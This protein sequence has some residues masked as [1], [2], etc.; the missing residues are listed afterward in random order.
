MK[1]KKQKIGPFLLVLQGPTS[2]PQISGF[3]PEMVTC[4]MQCPGKGER[5]AE[6]LNLHH[7]LMTDDDKKPL[8]YAGDGNGNNN[9]IEEG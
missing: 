4:Q 6:C 1:S 5:N 2:D 9:A 3:I 7:G 8:V